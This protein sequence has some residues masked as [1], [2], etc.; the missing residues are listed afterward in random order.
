[1]PPIPRAAAILSAALL[2]P[3]ADVSFASAAGGLPG[4][5]KTIE[6]EYAD[7]LDAAAPSAPST[8]V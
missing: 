8:R 1:M 2:L 3:V 7:W 6:A 5:L 4:S